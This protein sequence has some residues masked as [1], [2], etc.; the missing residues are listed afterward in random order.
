MICL[1]GRKR[2]GENTRLKEYLYRLLDNRHRYE[3]MAVKL[4][5]S[6]MIGVPAKRVPP[7]PFKVNEVEDT[8]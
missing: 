1:A 5:V 7:P 6:K 4:T 2:S 3:T 8:L